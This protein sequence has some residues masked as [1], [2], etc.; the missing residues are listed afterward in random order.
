MK[1]G[2]RRSISICLSDIDKDRIIKHTNGKLYLQINTYDF[3]EPNQFGKDFSASHAPTKQEVEARKAGE[4]VQIHFLGDGRIWE[5]NTKLSD[6][7]KEDL[8]F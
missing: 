5:D 8:P 4:K 1:Q 2:R 6:N 3:D 7:E